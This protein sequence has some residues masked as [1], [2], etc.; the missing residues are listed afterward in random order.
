ME[1][2]QECRP[3]TIEEIDDLNNERQQPC[4]CYTRPEQPPKEEKPPCSHDKKKDCC[5]LL[6]EILRNGRLPE[7]FEIHKPK[8]SIKVK[9]ANLCCKFSHKTS[10]VP[11]LML[12]LKRFLQ[13]KRPVSDFEEKIQDYLGS[14][15][16]ERIE[17]LTV[18]L[19]A[20]EQVPIGVR[21]CAFEDR[22]DDCENPEVLDPRFF[23]KVWVQEA[24]RLGREI[25]YDR[26]PGPG[27]V[28]PWERI[29]PK[30]ADVKG[31]PKLTAPWPW[32]C[33]VNPLGDNREW[34]KNNDVTEPGNIPIEKFIFEKH[35][36]SRICKQDTSKPVEPNKF[37]L[38]C[39]NEEA[40][41]ISGGFGG[42][43]TCHGN[44][45]YN[46]SQGGKTYCLKIP[47]VEPGDSVT[48][49]G[50][51]FFSM[52]SKVLLK[53]IDGPFENIPPI[54]CTVLGDQETPDDIHTCQVQDLMTFTIP[55]RVKDKDGLNNIPLPPGRY[56][57]QVQVP[58]EIGYAPLPGSAPSEFL[59][60]IVWLDVM[61]HPT[62]SFR[63]FTDYAFC[64]EET[65][66]PGSDEPWFQAFSVT[67]APG[68]SGTG[69]I[70]MIGQ[71]HI[72]I[73]KG[74]DVDSGEPISISAPPL[75]QGSFQKGMA[76]AIAI[77]GLEV[78][79]ED[80]AKKQIK[81]FADAYLEY[82]K[83]FFTQ[84]LVAADLEIVKELIRAGI[85][86]STVI[87]AGIGGL[88]AIALIGVL[89]ALWA[90]ADPI[91]VDFMILSAVGL[92][93][94]TNPNKPIPPPYSRSFGELGLS[95]TPLQ[96]KPEDIQP[97][98]THRTYSED[99]IYTSSE[100]N[101]KYRFTY[102]VQR[103]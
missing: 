57:V 67:F 53:K 14:L 81:D 18:G 85:A 33:A 6:L 101:S 100:E 73:V 13:G 22:F 77:I 1:R 11:V 94:L 96:T 54:N 56:S 19:K 78:D 103:I 88:I 42:I 50:L 21:K 2:P 58:N 70:T 3:W 48:L 97:G 55:T 28:R 51:N 80:A 98:G 45:R 4:N 79:S 23:F 61:V 92:H 84:T 95:V 93:D 26:V 72:E 52:N 27:K 102:K 15:P 83:S 12:F 44:S 17:A 36:F 43:G 8:Q 65:D 38:I 5:E 71:R 35:E 34:F 39:M 82:W 89:Y 47:E 75:F 86:T 10:V 20:Y 66:G 59:S 29:F 91:A 24:I 25:L 62:E 90:P 16:D 46:Y 31:T 60:N 37:H 74:D 87:T 68:E 9:T 7:K 49:R 30:D 41:T 76:C 32:I 64:H 69:N 99:R 40:P 63:Y